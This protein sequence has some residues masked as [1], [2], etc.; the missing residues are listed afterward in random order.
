MEVRIVVGLPA[1]V[2]DAPRKR[3]D[4]SSTR[5]SSDQLHSWPE[6]LFPGVGWVPFEP[7]ASL[8]RADGVRGRDDHR[9]RS[10]RTT[11]TPAPTDGAAAPSRAPGRTSSGRTR[12]TTRGATGAAA[13]ARPDPG[14]CSTI[15]GVLVALLLPALIRLTIARSVTPRPCAS[16]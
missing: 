12:A 16:R 5:S 11:S 14:A 13:T 7:T 9:R 4:E 8:G 1:R 3:G 10:D 15:L 2:A 6:V